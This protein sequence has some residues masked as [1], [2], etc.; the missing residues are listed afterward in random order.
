MLLEPTC[1][2]A[3]DQC[4]SK[5][6]TNFKAIVDPIGEVAMNLKKLGAIAACDRPP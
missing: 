5:R 1:R 3:T 6:L 2:V 4:S